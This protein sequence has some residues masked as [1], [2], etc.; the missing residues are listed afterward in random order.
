MDG[1]IGGFIALTGHDHPVRLA[2]Q[3]IAQADEVILAKIVVLIEHRDPG[4]GMFF[5]M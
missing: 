1:R 2:T 3:A 4:L 5:R